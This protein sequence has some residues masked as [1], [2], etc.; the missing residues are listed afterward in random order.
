MRDTAGDRHVRRGGEHERYRDSAAP[1]HRGPDP[2]VRPDALRR[3]GAPGGVP[4]LHLRLPQPRGGR[5]RIRPHGG[6]GAARVR[7]GRRARL[8]AL[9]PPE[10]GD[11]RGPGRAAGAGRGRGARLQLRHV[12]DRDR[13]FRAPAA[14]ARDRV[15]RADL[16]RHAEVRPERARAVGRARR[17]GARRRCGRDRARAARDAG[18]RGGAGRDAGQPHAHDDRPPARRPVRRRPRRPAARDGRQYAARAGV[19]APLPARRRRRAVLGHQV[20]V[21]LLRP[22]R[23]VRADPRPGRRRADPRAARP[24]RHHPAARRVLDPERAA[25]DRGAAHAPVHQERAHDRRSAGAPSEG[26]ARPLPF[27][28]PRR[29][30]GPHPRCAVPGRARCSRSN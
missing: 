23:R 17:A 15:H 8:L 2:R 29:R 21:R 16:R 30:A 1:A 10:R 27:P 22:D 28:V 26:R 6:T 14:G 20:P 5:A 12:G 24:A 7:R 11:P 4:Q 25:A 3:L 19:P 18:R 9:Q 13:A